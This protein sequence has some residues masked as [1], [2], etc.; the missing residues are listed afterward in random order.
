MSTSPTPPGDAEPAPIPYDGDAEGPMRR[1]DMVL[2]KSPT[3]V[4][5]PSVAIDGQ[6]H[7]L[8]WGRVAFEVPADRTVRVEAWIY[9]TRQMG[10]ASY[11]LEAGAP[12]RLEYL[13]PAAARF[14]GQLGPPGTVKRKGRIY[15][16]AVLFFVVLA[17]IPLIGL[18]V[19][20][21]ASLFR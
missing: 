10:R 3:L 11:A 15:L 14:P 18:V 12:A 21:V 7:D 20:L 9:L 13:A 5:K 17:L 1:L 8:E 6:F 4:V 2:R 19:L 16:A